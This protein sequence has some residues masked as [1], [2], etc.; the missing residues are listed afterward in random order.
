MRN[1]RSLRIMTAEGSL[2]G[3]V[4]EGIFVFK[5]IPYAAPPWANFAGRRRN[6]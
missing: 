6:H 1:E 5:G 3:S 2:L 4:E